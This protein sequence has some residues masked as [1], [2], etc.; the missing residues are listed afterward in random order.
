MTDNLYDDA[1][2]QEQADLAKAR[3]SPLWAEAVDFLKT[4]LAEALDDLRKAVAT[5]SKYGWVAPY[6]HG[7]GTAVRNL[8]RQH[9]FGEQEFGIDNLDNIYVALVEE[10][11]KE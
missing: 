11:A 5:P 4:N 2:K 6:H 9:K 1:K 10:A 3:Q 7:W 8:L